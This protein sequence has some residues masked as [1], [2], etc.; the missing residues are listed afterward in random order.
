MV[1]AGISDTGA[2]I[3]E[4]LAIGV[5]DMQILYGVS[6]NPVYDGSSPIKADRYITASEVG[7]NSWGSVVSVRVEL[8]FR[9]S[10]PVYQE[11]EGIDITFNNAQFSGDDNGRFMRQTVKSTVRVRNRGVL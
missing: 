8:M 5:E 9:S 6:D 2:Q 4:E 7:A 10:V 3:T 11:G 1:R